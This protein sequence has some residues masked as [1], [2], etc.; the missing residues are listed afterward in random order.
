MRLIMQSP[1]WHCEADGRF[2]L[3]GFAISLRHAYPSLDYRPLKPVAIKLSESAERWRIEYI[4][5]DARSVVIDLGIEHGVPSIG[6]SLNGFEAAPHWIHPVAG[7]EPKGANRLFRQGVGFSGP[8]NV[9]ALKTTPELFAYESYLITG[10]LADTGDTLAITARD[11]R[12]FQQ[13]TELYNRVHRRNFRNRELAGGSLHLD[14]GFSTEHIPLEDG[15]LTLPTLYLHH[16]TEPFSTLREAA[17]AIATASGAR[18]RKPTFHWCSWY[19]RASHFTCDDLAEFIEHT[20]ALGI[21]LDT[22]QIDDGY[23]LEGDWLVPNQRWPGGLKR[24]FDEIRQRGYAPGIWVAPYMVECRSRLFR[25]HPDWMLKDAA[26]EI[27]KAR[28]CYDGTQYSEEYYI[29]DTSHPEAF[30]YLRHVFSTLREWGAIYF[31]TDFVEWG[32]KDSTTVQ[33]HTPGKTSAEYHDDVCRMIREAIGED[34]YW[35]GCIAF[36]A[37]YIGYVDGM[38]VS[39]DVGL[40]WGSTGGT[41]NDGVGGGTLNVISETLASQYFNNVFWQN[42][43]DA[44]ILRESHQHYRPG[45]QETLAL[46]FGILGVAINTSDRFHDMSPERLALWNFLRPQPTPW[47]AHLP[48]QFDPARKLT[49]ATRDFANTSGKALLIA[50]LTDEAVTE[51]IDLSQLA[52]AEGNLHAFEWGPEGAQPLGRLEHICP[53]IPS[54][55]ALLYYLSHDGTPPPTGLTLGGYIPEPA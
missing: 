5:P 19:Q 3:A 54:H 22:V 41:G 15:R 39:S 18:V 16:G 33:R 23:C 32:Y 51:A 13:K 27:I 31:K 30:E 48:F 10:L 44:L 12:R 14:A 45:E 43:P 50:N 9:V 46:L 53:K 35:L 25:K 11:T 7:A 6:T 4:L 40:S 34:A 2:H 42:D 21:P 52:G 47:T 49:V 37:P 55:G 1:H 17:Q 20:R 28:T 26:G 29:L 36:F 8:T 38:R 24:A